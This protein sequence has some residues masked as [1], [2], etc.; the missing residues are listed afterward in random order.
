[1]KNDLDWDSPLSGGHEMSEYEIRLQN[2]AKWQDVSQ[3]VKQR[4][5]CCQMCHSKNNLRAHHLS[6]DDFYDPDNLVALCDKCHSQVHAFTK[7]FRENDSKIVQALKEVNEVI[8]SIIDPFVIERCA[9]LSPNGDIYFFTGPLD[10][11]VKLNDFI[12]LL[13][14][15]DPYSNNR[16]VNAHWDDYIRNYGN[17]NFSRYQKMRLERRRHDPT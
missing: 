1:M 5:G 11:R 7:A 3:Y 9:E 15:L 17:S 12:Q 2:D 13:I 8:S 4:D 14:T 16:Q 10:K 6:Y